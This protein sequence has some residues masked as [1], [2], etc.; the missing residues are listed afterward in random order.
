SAAIAATVEHRD[1]LEDTGP[2]HIP[3]VLSRRFHKKDV[4]KRF[5]RFQEPNPAPGGSPNRYKPIPWPR[6]RGHRLAVVPP[7]THANGGHCHPP[8]PPL[9][10]ARVGRLGNPAATTAMPAVVWCQSL[11]PSESRVS[12]TRVDILSA[13]R[14]ITDG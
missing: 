11:F 2:T 5:P 10:L 13:F 3:G 7:T 8:C 14:T 9:P 12:G 6:R 4:P 1:S